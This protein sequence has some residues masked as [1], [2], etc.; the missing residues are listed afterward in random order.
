MGN[1]KLKKLM[2]SKD[3]D[4]RAPP[5][6]L[7]VFALGLRAAKKAN[8]KFEQKYQSIVEKVI[9]A[10]G[11]G[12]LSVDDIERIYTKEMSPQKVVWGF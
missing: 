7:W 9:P 11:I 2:E 6:A 10:I 8:P 1:E 12:S 5:G 3:F 4:K